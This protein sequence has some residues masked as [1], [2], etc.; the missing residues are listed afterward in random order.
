[1]NFFTLY[2]CTLEFNI[3]IIIIIII[4][5]IIITKPQSNRFYVL[6]AICVSQIFT[7]SLSLSF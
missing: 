1:M 4:I 2:V 3:I 6:P 5:K 7:L